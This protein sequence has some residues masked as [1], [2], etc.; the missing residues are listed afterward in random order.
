MEISKY[1]KDVKRLRE[2]GCSRPEICLKLNLTSNQVKYLLDKYKGGIDKKKSVKGIRKFNL[3]ERCI[4]KMYRTGISATEIASTLDWSPNRITSFL[5]KNGIYKDRYA[6]K[7]PE[8]NSRIPFTDNERD[9][10]LEG[11]RDGK[12]Y[13]EIALQLKRSAN[14][15]RLE[16]K[17]MALI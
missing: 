17:K 9:I 6:R 5:Y 15:V 7:Y 12:S 3:V 4:I 14:S 13:V 16:M 10:I 1:F 8:K 2:E 11:W